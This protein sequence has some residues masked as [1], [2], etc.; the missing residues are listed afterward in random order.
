MKNKVVNKNLD[1]EYEKPFLK[2]G[3]L[4]AGVDEAGRG[5][6]AG[7]VVAA[8]VILNPDFI[9]TCGITDSKKLTSKKRQEMFEIIKQNSLSIG[10]GITDNLII[11]EINIL[12]ATISAMHDA[13]GKLTHEPNQLLI[14][15]NYFKENGIPY[16]TIVKGDSK[17]LSIASASIIAKVTRDKWMA[18]VADKKYPQY[19]FAKNKGYGTKEH[20]KAIKEHGTCEIHRRTFLKKFIEP[21]RRMF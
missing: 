10:I 20:L 9:N 18:D 1:F 15:G 11:D 16:S 8:A 17:C 13:I 12:Q 19:L 6:L 4:V 21:E 5:P 2:K 14:D 3:L 7:P